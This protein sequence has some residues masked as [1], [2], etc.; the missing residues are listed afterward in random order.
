MSEPKVIL[1]SGKAGSGKDTTGVFLK[2]ALEEKGKKVLIIHYADLVKYICTNF[3]GWD[4]KK[5]EA[6][7][8]LLQYVGTDC[9]RDQHDP[10]YWVSFVI[11]ML[12]FFGSRWDYAIIPDC[13]FKNE[14]TYIRDCMFDAIHIRVERP[15]GFSVLT[16]EQKN[17]KSETELDG[18][19]PD[20]TVSNDDGIL[21]LW[22]KVFKEVVPI[23]LEWG[24]SD[25]F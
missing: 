25:A 9:V 7:R 10:N 15:E 14:I 1:I 4:G 20:L 24:V 5:D 11:D 22:N 19:T 18:I 21:S 16:E 17:H 8:E 13:R 3:F 12:D 6:G 2:E 23:V